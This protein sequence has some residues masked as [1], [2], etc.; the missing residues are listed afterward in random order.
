MILIPFPDKKYDV[1]YADP[2]WDV[3]K[4]QRRS[5]P[6][7]RHMDY[8]TMSLS[9]I[10]SLPVGDITR[11]DCTLWIWTTHAYLPKTFDVIDA[12]GFRY[13]RTVTWDKQNGMCLFGFHHRSEFL[14][15]SYKGKLEMYPHR[16]TFP[17]V[18]GV[19]SKRHSQKPQVFRDLIAPFGNERIELFARERVYGWD[20]WG[21]EV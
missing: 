16:K 12:W 17:T 4:I 15:F 11:T 10:C 2:P 5:R 1:I 3:R 14:L 18:V 9:E 6:N 8:P 13:Q 7:Q 19:K 20:A 21:N